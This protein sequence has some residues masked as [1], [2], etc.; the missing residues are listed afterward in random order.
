MDNHTKWEY[1]EEL[2]AR[3][4]MIADD[5]TVICGLPN[6]LPLDGL[7]ERYDRKEVDRMRANANLIVAA[8]NACIELNPSNPLAVAEAIKDMHEALKVILPAFNYY[9]DYA[10]TSPTM[11]TLNAKA[12]DNAFATLSKIGG[13]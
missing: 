6:P 5:S 2:A 10:D 1:T 13:K 3:M 4:S 11:R 8:V 9:L 7:T 12:R